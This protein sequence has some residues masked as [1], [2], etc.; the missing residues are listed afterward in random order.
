MIEIDCYNNIVLLLISISFV[1]FGLYVYLESKKIH[2]GLSD[3]SDRLTN[4]E[5]Y[6]SNQ[7]SLNVH[8]N[9]SQ[10]TK[11]PMEESVT[12]SVPSGSIQ[13]NITSTQPS[14]TEDVRNHMDSFNPLMGFM[15]QTNPF[16][17]NNSSQNM[18]DKSVNKH[19]DTDKNNDSDDGPDSNSDCDSDSDPDSDSEAGSDS[20]SEAGSDSDSEAGSDSDSDAGS[21]RDSEA[22]S[23]RDSKAGEVNDTED[24]TEN[25]SHSGLVSNLPVDSD[26]LSVPE[27]NNESIL[28]NIHTKTVN[29]LKQICLEHNLKVSGNKSVLIQRIKDTLS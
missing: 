2:L 15:N 7:H 25:D 8:S 14:N 1:C 10:K 21:D 17:I 23:D 6:L 16:N 5:L 13:E 18:S 27:K 4:L 9:P 11:N 22:G 19:M 3:C 29:E 20:D 28:A 12:K 24:G 26:Q